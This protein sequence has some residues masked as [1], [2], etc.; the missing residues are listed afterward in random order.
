M[1]D[2]VGIPSTIKH[3][4]GR[5]SLPAEHIFGTTLTEDDYRKLEHVGISRDTAVRHAGDYTGREVTGILKQRLDEKFHGMLFFSSWPREN[6]FTPIR[7]YL[8]RR[9]SPPL[10]EKPNGTLKE[11][12][13][14]LAPPGSYNQLFLPPRIQT[15]WLTDPSFDLIVTEGPN[16]RRPRF[17]VARCRRFGRATARPGRQ[18]LR[19]I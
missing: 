2:L 15:D 7:T 18:H 6:G 14:Y 11:G 1:A 3:L 5:D 9:D 13:K 4:V 8:L 17:D 12:Q 16:S 19:G 10:E